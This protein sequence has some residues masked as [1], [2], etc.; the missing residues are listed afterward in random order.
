LVSAGRLSAGRRA[1]VGKERP[2]V[3]AAEAVS[4]GIEPAG[5]EELAD[6]DGG[7][8]FFPRRRDSA[9]LPAVQLGALPNR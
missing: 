5:C 9:K 4:V 1:R 7:P 3:H 8:V 2:G 6:R